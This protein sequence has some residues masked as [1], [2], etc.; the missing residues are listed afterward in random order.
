M[1]TAI[2]YLAVAGGGALGAMLRYYLSGSALSRAAAPFPTATFLINVSGCFVVG[3]LLTLVSD[4]IPVNPHLRL[5][6]ATGFVGAYTTFSA[7]EY[8]TAKLVEQHRYVVAG[9]YV[10]LSLVVGFCAVWAGMVTARKV[11]RSQ[12]M[13]KMN[14]FA[15]VRTSEGTHM[16]QSGH[17]TFD[18]ADKR[19]D[20]Q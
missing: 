10:V 18:P 3:F 17:D 19:G 5:A 4:R 14:A 20:T 8:E 2:R 11:E 16:T 12:V 15:K 1:E 6:I 7:F 9:V 13:T